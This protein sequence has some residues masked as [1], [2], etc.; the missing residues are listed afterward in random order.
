[1][2]TGTG[3]EFN[4]QQSVDFEGEPSAPNYKTKAPNFGISATVGFRDICILVYMHMY[5]S[6]LY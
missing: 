4:S 1:M 2:V 5:A 3:M 6:M